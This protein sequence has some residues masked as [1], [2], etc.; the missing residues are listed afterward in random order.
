MNHA[1]DYQ[2]G[3]NDAIAEAKR[4]IQIN[5]DQDK[6]ATPATDTARVEDIAAIDHIEPL[7]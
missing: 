7:A 3:W 6:G 5:R 4:A 2:Q 1:D